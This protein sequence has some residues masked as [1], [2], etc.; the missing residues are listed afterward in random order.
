MNNHHPVSRAITVIMTL[1]YLLTIASCTV[2]R[3]YGVLVWK[4]ENLPFPMGELVNISSIFSV[5]NYYE[6]DYS[7]TLVQV[8][9]WQLQFFEK[10]DEAKK[11]Q[12]AFQPY[13]NLYVF[14]LRP[15]GLPIRDSA[16]SQAGMIGKL[17]TAQLA[18][19]IGRDVEKTKIDRWEDY[20]YTIL[21]EDG[22]RG[23]VFGYYLK[24]VES[25][26]DLDEKV[27]ELIKAD[28]AL[29]RFLKN[30]WYPVKTAEM[31]QSGRIDTEYLDKN[32]NLLPRPEQNRIIVSNEDFNNREFIYST[33]KKISGDTYAFSGTDLTVQVFPS[34]TINV[35]YLLNGSHVYRLFTLIDKNMEEISKN[36][37][38][39][40]QNLL[41]RFTNKGSSLESSEYGTIQLSEDAR[42]VW[43][44]FDSLQSIIP[45]GTAGR[46]TV[47]FSRYLGPAIA[48]AYDGV[49]TFIFEDYP[50][51]GVT[52]VYSFRN[53]GVRFLYTARENIRDNQVVRIGPS[54]FVLFFTFLN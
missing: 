36:E 38:S 53:K 34:K 21:T 50:E 46:G 47:N 41:S 23:S 7:G 51:Y 48:D 2:Y 14:T 49:I 3:G 19:V 16:T 22:T 18:K 17:K 35:G 45:P 30:S 26:A 39:R 24:T 32:Y 11:Y 33:I 9:M 13:V 52:F 29:E 54:P 44:N 8:P 37:S 31:L 27:Q 5:D 25:A 43:T 10:L 20:W 1:C 28:P 6:V 15:D 42:F 12:A 40:N 4:N